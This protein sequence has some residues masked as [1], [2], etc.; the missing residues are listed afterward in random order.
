MS[1]LHAIGL[2]G[3]QQMRTLDRFSAL[4]SV[5]GDM[6]L[7]RS[8]SARSAMYWVMSKVSSARVSGAPGAMIIGEGRR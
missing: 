8:I 2:G 3:S 7:N 4:L 6:S 1:A 5:R